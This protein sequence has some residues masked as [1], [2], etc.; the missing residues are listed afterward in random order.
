MWCD[1]FKPHYKCKNNSNDAQNCNEFHL[2]N[3]N[4]GPESGKDYWKVGKI[5]ILENPQLWFYMKKKFVLF[6]ARNGSPS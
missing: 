2:H 6:P 4:D 5:V 1:N 3:F